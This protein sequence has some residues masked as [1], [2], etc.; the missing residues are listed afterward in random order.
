MDDTLPNPLKNFT[1][2]ANP[3]KVV[4]NDA[5][6][7]ANAPLSGEELQNKGYLRDLAM[8]ELVAI[9]RANGGDIKGVAAIKELLDRTEG[10]PAQT[11]DLNQ[12][13]GIVQIVMEASK[14][15]NVQIPLIDTLT[16]ENAK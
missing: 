12:K 14:L 11:V 6:S 15:R 16:L 1:P 4:Q 9:V 3:P 10:K 8:R 5:Q 7:P 2:R 13:I